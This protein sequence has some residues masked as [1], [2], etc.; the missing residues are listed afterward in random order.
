M[1]LI[2]HFMDTLN[3][4]IRTKV[5]YIYINIIIKYY[6]GCSCVNDVI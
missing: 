4:H 6:I 2:N 5:T 1:E 3:P